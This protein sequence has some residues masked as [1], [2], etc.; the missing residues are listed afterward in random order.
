M[1]ARFWILTAS[2][3]GLWVCNRSLDPARDVAALQVSGEEK[4]GEDLTTNSTNNTNEH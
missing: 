3:V 4:I 2:V 1:R